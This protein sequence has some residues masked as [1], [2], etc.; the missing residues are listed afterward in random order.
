MVEV[1]S[2]AIHRLERDDWW[3]SVHT[4]LDD[5]S[6]SATKSYEDETQ[7]LDRTSPDGL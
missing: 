3:A 2:D 6:P 7:K 4:A 1:V 5:M